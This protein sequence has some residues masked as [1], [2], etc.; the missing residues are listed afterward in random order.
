MRIQSSS[1]FS[2]YLFFLTLSLSSTLH[3]DEIDD[4]MMVM[5]RGFDFFLDGI[6][7]PARL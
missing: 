7:S 5:V 1:R 2:F 6:A 4:T 3:C